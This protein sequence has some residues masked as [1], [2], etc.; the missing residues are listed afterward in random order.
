MMR[1]ATRLL[2]AQFVRT[3]ATCSIMLAISGCEQANRSAKSPPPEK[4]NWPEVAPSALHA[5]YLHSLGYGGARLDLNSN[6]SFTFSSG[7]CMTEH[8]GSGRF[9]IESG[10]VVLKSNAKGP[11]EET[12]LHYPKAKNIEWNPRRLVP[13]AWDQRLYLI[14]EDRVIEFCNQINFG[15]EPRTDRGA[16]PFL[17]RDGDER[18]PVD[19]KPS[20]PEKYAQYLIEV[21][22][23]ATVVK[24]D[25][26]VLKLDKGYDDGLRVGL[27][28]LAEL[29]GEY[30]YTSVME[31]VSVDPQSCVV[32]VRGGRWP[33]PGE[34]VFIGPPTSNH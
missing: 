29:K 11:T 23:T 1:I 7:C 21:P 9:E 30:S 16:Y 19:G 14:D 27:K 22:F 17:L 8:E 15:D 34:T 28:M 33:Q 10:V 6:G 4:I 12:K 20:L 3:L 31:V 2:Q 24:Q 32:E 13:I 5:K 26:Y 18:K 25:E